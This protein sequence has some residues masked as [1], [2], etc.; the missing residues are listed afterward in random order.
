MPQG[1]SMQFS[2]CPRSEL[3][4]ITLYWRLTRSMFSQKLALLLSRR[5]HANNMKDPRT[6][7]RYR[8]WCF[9]SNF[10]YR[11]SRK[12]QLRRRRR[13]RLL[14]R[15]EYVFTLSKESLA[16]T[17]NAISHTMP[18]IYETQ[19]KKRLQSRRLSNRTLYCMRK[20][21]FVILKARST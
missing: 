14:R 12:D 10:N 13:P 2:A 1:F 4:F 5:H 17:L 8:V 3:L 21:R 16:L 20:A 7:I 15:E 6:K 11:I 19:I 18:N 9:I